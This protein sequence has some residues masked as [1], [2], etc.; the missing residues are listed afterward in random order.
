MSAYGG[1]TN[2]I[3]AGN[4]GQTTLGDPAGQI[5]GSGVSMGAGNTNLCNGAR[6]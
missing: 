2:N 5:T 4:S 6:S 3:C 1:Y